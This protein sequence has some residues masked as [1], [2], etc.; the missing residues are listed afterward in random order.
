MRSDLPTGTVT[1][2]FT[3]IEGST[4]LLDRL[5]DGYAA[6]AGR[7]QELL[8]E[9]FAAHGGREVGTEGDSFFVVFTS[10][11]SA[12]AA[13]AE[14]QRLLAGNAWPDGAEV[15]VRMGLHTGEGVLGGDNYVGIEVNRAA[16]IAAAGHGG[17]IVLSAAARALVQRA[18][19][20]G[21]TLRYLGEHGL[22]DLPAPEH[23]FQ[24]DV[25]GLPSDFPPLRT[26]VVPT[27]LP[28]QVTSF[29]GRERE[30]GEV[31]TLLEGTRLLTLTG[32]GG[33]GKTR[34]S[35]EAA[36]RALGSFPGGV[37][38]VALAPISEAELV[39]STIAQALGLREVPNQ[40]HVETL[41]EHLADRTTLIVLDNFEQVVD[42]AP[43]V[44]ELLAGTAGTRFLVTS[45]EVLHIAGEQEY[46]VPPLGVPD[47]AHLPPLASLS[48]FEAVRLFV[49]RARAVRP[50][51]EVTNENAPAVAE[52]CA[53]LEGLPLAIELAAA[54]VKILTPQAI[55]GRLEKR[56]TFLAGGSRDLP[57][58][59]QTLRGAIAWSYDLLDRNERAFFDRLGAFVGGFTVEAAD[60]I[61]NPGGECGMDTLDGLS[62]LADKS[63]IRQ[64]E[65]HHG[66]PRFLMLETIREFALERLRGSGHLD[67]VAGRHAR[68]FL[69][70][71]QEA[72]PRVFG[73]DAATWLDRVGHEHDNVRSAIGWAREHGEVELALRLTASMWRFWQIRGHLHEG[74]MRLLEALDLPGVDAHPGD[75]ANALEAAGGTAYWMDRFDLAG[76]FYERCL[77]VRRRL[78]DR[79]AVAR[80]LYNLSFISSLGPGTRN[81]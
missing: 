37:F 6:V 17:Q 30:L 14:A 25:A 22:K 33:T 64:L 75:L 19:P 67:Q 69:R 42:A 57:I 61:A 81:D 52:I 40:S 60:E 58:R 34:L 16:R 35:L 10:A 31:A 77:E 47:P 9:A 26:L 45:R 5:G 74:L 63:L 54:R 20:D 7:H 2:L 50:A 21:V 13:A 1:F 71:A 76:D 48:Q 38:F 15:R 51:F 43:V 46:P 53:R 66:E 32:P 27:N 62:A 65:T 11:S 79:S 18:L 23:L 41:K 72:A 80:A 29:I 78:D 12:L 73:S 44:A 24:A 49:E 28:P 3:D 70:L 56:L 55:L 39:P 68:T 59:Q 8:R 36:R 4:R